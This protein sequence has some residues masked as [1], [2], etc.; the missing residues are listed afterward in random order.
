MHVLRVSLYAGH[1]RR[2]LAESRSPRGNFSHDSGRS[3]RSSGMMRILGKRNIDINSGWLSTPRHPHAAERSTSNPSVR[4]LPR[5]KLSDPLAT[6]FIAVVALPEPDS[7][8]RMVTLEMLTAV[9]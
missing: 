9:P 5:L 4:G 3:R 7:D 6:S 1:S 8:P 2:T